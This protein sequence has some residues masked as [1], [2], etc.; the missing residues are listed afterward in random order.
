MS[1]QD[2]AARPPP[3]VVSVVIPNYN[4]A[5][6]LQERFASVAAQTYQARETI[7]LDDAS[8]DGS[9]EMVADFAARSGGTVLLNE[10]NSGNAFRQWRRGIEQSRGTYIWIAES[11]DRADPRFLE[12]MVA[13]LEAHPQC[14]IAYCGSEAIDEA[15][16]SLGPA[17][18]TLCRADPGRWADDYVACG[19]AEIR[20]CLMFES[21]IPNASAVLFRRSAYDA[22]GG[23]DDSLRLCGDWKLW[24][25][26]LA[27]GD[28]AYTAECLNAFRRHDRSVRSRTSVGLAFVETMRTMQFAAG[29]VALNREEE[30]RLRGRLWTLCLAALSVNRPAW[31]DVR[32]VLRAARTL[33]VGLGRAGVA[34]LLA[35]IG[36]GVRRRLVTA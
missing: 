8:T 11:D 24:C 10:Q 18:D 3:P 2:S 23:V 15:G 25:A 31:P 22:V 17:T 19:R 1:D 33:P 9:R 28:V 16:A 27:V 34:E 29:L 7:L 5:R 35:G 12:R 32:A 14:S 21:T 4:H 36:R 30:Q 26:L 20:E 6:F 13:L